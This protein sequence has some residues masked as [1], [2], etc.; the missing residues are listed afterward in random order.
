MKSK[1]YDAAYKKTLALY[2]ISK[3]QAE[4]KRCESFCP[5]R[6]FCT[7]GKSLKK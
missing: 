6:E 5:V 1:D 7:F 4:A 2:S 3:R